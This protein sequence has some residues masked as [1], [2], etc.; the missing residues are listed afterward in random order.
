MVEIKKYDIKPEHVDSYYR[1]LNRTL[2]FC[3][4]RHLAGKA[5]AGTSRSERG[6]QLI[7]ANTAGRLA[8]VLDCSETKTQNLC[9]AVGICFPQYGQEG[10]RAVKQYIEDQHID[11]NPQMLE[12][13]LAEYQIRKYRELVSTEFHELLCAYFAGSEE[14]D[15]VRIVRFVQDLIR[16]VKKATAFYDG[17]SGDLLYD[18]TQEAVEASQENKEL[19]RGS[20]L[21]GYDEKIAAYQLPQLTEEESAEV[22]QTLDRYIREFDG[23]PEEAVLTHIYLYD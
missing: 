1:R 14:P 22:H 17:Y 21:T 6:Y 7:A 11:L 2:E 10:L 16:N 8:R 20:I 9:M 5:E 23:S 18:V 13:T 3:V 12:V 19:M 15:E 4:S